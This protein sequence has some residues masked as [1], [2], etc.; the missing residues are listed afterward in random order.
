MHIQQNI[1]KILQKGID[2]PNYYVII[3]SA[4]KYYTCLQVIKGGNF[5][6]TVN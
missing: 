6:D 5:Y 1:F 3:I 2:K 4:G